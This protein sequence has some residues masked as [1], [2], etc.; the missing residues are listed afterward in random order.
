ML[1]AIA[2]SFEVKPNQSLMSNPTNSMLSMF[3]H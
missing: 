2:N 1:V 3:I